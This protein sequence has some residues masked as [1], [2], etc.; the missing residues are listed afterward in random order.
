MSEIMSECDNCGAPLD[1]LDGVRCPEC[2]RVHYLDEDECAFF[3]GE[4]WP[5]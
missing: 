3:G 5:V 1:A 2:G 4:V